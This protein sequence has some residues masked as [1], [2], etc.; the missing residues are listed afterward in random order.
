MGRI[1]M[2]ALHKK[3]C[4][5]WFRD[6]AYRE[7]KILGTSIYARGDIAKVIGAFEP[8][9][10][11]RIRLMITVGRANCGHLGGSLSAVEV[12]TASTEWARASRGTRT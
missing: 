1:A 9:R 11:I 5:I 8:A 7:Q 6:L 12:L 4:E 3:P 10:K 2:V